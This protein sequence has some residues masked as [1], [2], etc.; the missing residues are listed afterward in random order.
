[1]SHLLTIEKSFMMKIMS[2]ILDI[3]EIKNAGSIERLKIVDDLLM[4]IGDLEITPAYKSELMKRQLDI[5]NN[6]RL[7]RSWDE[8]RMGRRT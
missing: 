6:P 7:G 5:E 8:V 3:P 4:S 2:T 1:M